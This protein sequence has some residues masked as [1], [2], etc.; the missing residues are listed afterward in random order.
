[1]TT[2]T[3]SENDAGARRAEL[4]ANLDRVT[5]RLD[6]ALSAAG[7]PAGDADLLVV[8]KFFP[9]AD[10][11]TLVELGRREF[12]ESREP[13]A[14][15]KVADVVESLPAGLERTAVAF[16][17]IG[18]VQRKKARSVARWARRVH[19]VDSP[20][21][22]EALA[23]AA[24]SALDEG[25]RT[26]PLGVLLQV[27]LDED[28]ARGGAA[29]A[30]LPALA[31]AVRRSPELALQGLMAIAPTHG[32]R[33]DWMSTLASIREDFVRRHPDA[34]VL[35]AGMSQDLEA[36]IEFGSTC[37]RVGTAILGTRPI[38]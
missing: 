2:A 18:S 16:D 28:P 13:E 23:R 15:R 27:S 12:G 7:R 22:V 25:A 24:S 34:T 37:V 31:D 3:G 4:A 38:P 17:M 36:A 14:S 8:T 1:M 32:E 26:A 19:S 35:S 5:A 20:A 10:V 9:A 33:S 11:A 6:A 29:R 21:L 30:A